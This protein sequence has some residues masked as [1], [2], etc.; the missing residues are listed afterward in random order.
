MV[1]SFDFGQLQEWGA[2]L[3]LPRYLAKQI[4][5]WVAKRGV[6]DWEKMTNLSKA[7]RELLAREL[8]FELELIKEQAE[9]EVI[10]YLWRLRDGKAVESVLILSEDRRTVC[11]SSQ[12]GCAARCAFCASGQN[13]LIR[14]LSGGEIVE[15]VVRIHG[16]LAARGERV[17]HVV[18]MGMGEPLHNREAVFRAIRYLTDPELMGLSRRRITVSTVGVV[19]GIRELA[20]S[21]LDVNLALSLHAPDQELRRR[22]IPYARQVELEPLME[23]VAAYSE[24]T[25]RNMTYEYTLMAGVNDQP[26]HAT[27]LAALLEGQQC[28]VNCIPYNPVPG[29]Q[30]E[31][32]SR[33]AVSQFMRTLRGHGIVATCRITKGDDI[34]AACGQLAL[35]VL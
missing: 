33:A 24:R 7:N 11:V 21:G 16:L 12:V 30:L 10:K 31:R 1:C 13:G 14:D 35:P 6:A 26:E 34:A 19:E 2:G 3:G 15:Q 5:E 4:V 8:P 17:S 27:A 18:F 29:R 20:E 28:S 22:L 32:P 23:A 25:G 9:G